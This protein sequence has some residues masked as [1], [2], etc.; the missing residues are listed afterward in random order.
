MHAPGIDAQELAAFGRF[1]LVG[2]DRAP[3]VL[4]D[5]DVEVLNFLQIGKRLSGQEK[6]LRV[7]R[8]QAGRSHRVRGPSVRSRFLPER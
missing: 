7:K 4:G 5:Q 8:H 2:G 6:T 1:D 3:L